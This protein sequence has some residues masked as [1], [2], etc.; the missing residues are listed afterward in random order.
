MTERDDNLALED[1][2]ELARDA[3]M[4]E[5]HTSLPARVLSYDAAT[6]TCSVRPMVRR[7]LPTV[8]DGLVH[9]ALPD[10]HQVPVCW[11]RAGAWFV[12]M[13][14]AAG[15]FVLVVCAERDFARWRQT[16]DVGDATDIRNHTLSHAIAIPGVYPRTRQL[17]DTPSDALVIGKDGGA[18]V[19]IKANGDILI[20]T[21][22]T[23]LVALANLVKSRIDTIQA[24]FD[25]HTHTVSGGAT[26]VP[27]SLIGP[28]AGV[29]AA[30]ARAE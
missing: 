9:E 7:P 18:T 25:T 14:L 11:P 8:S 4:N 23:E 30:K 19:R 10:V 3:W 2:L 21:N 16:G 5:L 22:A 28:L 13:P 17:S 29:A 24:A 20:G 27:A 6:Q 12:H 15:D 1:V 26:L